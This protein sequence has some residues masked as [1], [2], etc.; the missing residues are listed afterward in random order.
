MKYQPH[1]YES[2][3]QQPGVFPGKRQESFLSTVPGV[4]YGLIY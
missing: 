1:L 4:N 2:V 3:R